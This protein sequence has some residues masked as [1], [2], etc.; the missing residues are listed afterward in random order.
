[1]L[2]EV[3]GVGV[4]SGNHVPENESHHRYITGR[5]SIVQ[6]GV[7]GTEWYPVRHIQQIAPACDQ[8]R[9]ATVRSSV[10]T[11]GFMDAA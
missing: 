11:A 10:Q 2:L 8:V 5:C 7:N 9:V 1:M 3:G 6:H 4:G